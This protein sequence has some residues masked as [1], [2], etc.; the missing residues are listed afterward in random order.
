MDSTKTGSNAPSSSPLSRRRGSG[1]TFDGLMNQKR[2]S[3][4]SSLARRA[5]LNDQRPQAGF[6]G[7]M[8][9]NQSRTVF[10]RIGLFSIEPG[11][12]RDS[13]GEPADLS[14]ER[15]D[16][17]GPKS[18]TSQKL[19][20]VDLFHSY[21][22]SF[23]RLREASHRLHTDAKEADHCFFFFT[24]WD[25]VLL[26]LVR[27]AGSG[28]KWLLPRYTRG[29]KIVTISLAPAYCPY[30]RAYLLQKEPKLSRYR[31]LSLAE[32]GGGG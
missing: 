16:Q 26:G 20:V 19:W 29:S 30:Y 13:T 27:D 31:Q 28:A 18:H 22:S 25:W 23:P 3:D 21:E 2:T 17:P 11:A 1:P 15:R 32:L 24:A 12:F 6:F 5:S 10:A 9:H 7:Q 4:P 8:W 14:A